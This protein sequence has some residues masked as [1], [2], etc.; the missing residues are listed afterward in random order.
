MPRNHASYAEQAEQGK[1]RKLKATPSFA[2]APMAHD[3]NVGNG[4][5]DEK[6]EYLDSATH[7]NGLPAFS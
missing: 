7:S 5:H 3:Q 1:Q 6:N 2:S 4:P